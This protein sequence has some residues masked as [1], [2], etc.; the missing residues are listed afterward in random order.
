MK[1]NMVKN[2]KV[3]KI[4]SYVHEI[5]GK[6]YE[7]EK[8]CRYLDDERI[9]SLMTLGFQNRMVN[10]VVAEIS[11]NS[12]VLQIG[13]TFG[14]QIEAVAEKIG[15]YGKYVVVDVCPQQ[16]ER[17]RSKA[18]YQKIDFQSHDGSR[19][20]SQKYDTVIC[21]M[22]LHQLPPA[23]KS[24]VINNALNSV[25][26]GGKVI[27]VDYHQP[28]KWNLLRLI[29]KP[30]NRI[31]QPFAESMWKRTIDS[32]VKNKEF[33]TWRK[34]VYAGKMY[35]KVVAVR[36]VPNFEKPESKPSYY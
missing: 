24:K 19:T 6:I 27:F 22:L 16:L 23:T 13:C 11:T 29:L 18:I 5:Y 15:A 3:V 17:C 1:Y 34:K 12:K 10:D 9:V 4:P 30:F 2:S 31:F 35:Q 26:E 28:A 33:F 8:L 32:Y 36:Q 21:Y 14:R 7:N 25:E 20:F